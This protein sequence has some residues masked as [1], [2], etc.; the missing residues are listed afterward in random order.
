VSQQLA[1]RDLEEL[2]AELVLCLGRLH[3]AIGRETIGL[4]TTVP[5]A[6]LRLLAQVEELGPVNIGALARADHCS[7]PTM[8][9]AVASLV[10]RGWATKRPNPDDARSSLVALTREGRGVLGTARDERA[11]VVSA[12]FDADEHHD[13]RDLATTVAV[14]RGLLEHDPHQTIDTH[15]GAR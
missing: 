3:R 9:A 12:R 13:S 11:A 15:E 4:S 8:S 10:E 1:E 14:L 2:S 6:S 7:Q 5:T